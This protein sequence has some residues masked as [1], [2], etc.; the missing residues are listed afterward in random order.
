MSVLHLCMDTAILCC[1]SV[2]LYICLLVRDYNSIY[3]LYAHN[4]TCTYDTYIYTYIH[5]YTAKSKV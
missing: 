4:Y 1:E 5:I 3:T 2:Q